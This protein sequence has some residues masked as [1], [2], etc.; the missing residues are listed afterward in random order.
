[1][2]QPEPKGCLSLPNTTQQT[3]QTQTS[4]STKCVD[5]T[6]AQTRTT[7][8]LKDVI[9]KF[10]M[11]VYGFMADAMKEITKNQGYD[12][13]DKFYLLNDKEVDTLCSIVRKQ[14]VSASGSTSG[15]AISN[16][17]QEHLKLAIFAMKHFK[18]VSCEIN[19]D[20]LTK[21]DIIAFSQ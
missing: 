15:H 16:L 9:K 11:S 6:M 1:M 3:N 5:S 20:S 13:L 7:I 18:R 8:T 21:K 17:A 14:H 4:P 10:L 2:P 19:L 12:K